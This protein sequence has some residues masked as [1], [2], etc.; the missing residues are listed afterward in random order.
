MANEKTFNTRIKLKYDSLA[1]WINNDPV[2]LSGEVAY[3][4]IPAA[5]NAATTA[6]TILFKVGDGVKRFSQLGWGSGLAADVYDWAKADSLANAPYAQNVTLSQALAAIESNASSDLETLSTAVANKAD[7]SVVSSLESNVNAALANKADSSV[8]SNLESNVNAALANKADSSAVSNLE[9]SVNAALANKANSSD[10]ESAI[11]NAEANASAAAANAE[12]NAKSYADTTASSA[13]ANAVANVIANAPADFDTLKEVADWIQSDTTGA[14]AMQIAISSLT[15][16]KADQSALEALSSVVNTKAD[17][18]EVSNINARLA[19][20]ELAIS[21]IQAE[22]TDI[23]AITQQSGFVIFDCG[24][25]S[26]N[27]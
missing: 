12:A 24:S 14:A 23:D 6:P 4:E 21:N 25:S 10:V 27:I 26:L 2:L 19:N 22:S 8:V 20:A 1:N 13:A 16:S 3:V 9:S 5:N 15:N 11:A 17:E 18:T 7:S